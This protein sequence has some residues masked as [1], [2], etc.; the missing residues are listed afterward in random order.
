MRNFIAQWFRKPQSNPSPGTIVDSPT[1]RPQ[2]QPQTARQ[3]RMEASLASLRLLP[4]GV[5]R[6]LESSGHR[7]V[8]DLLRLNL[9]QW[10]TEQR[11]TASQQSQLRTVRRAIRMAFAL[12]AMHPREAYLL[13]AIHRRS[14]EDVASDSPRHLFRDLE[15]FALSSRGRALT[16]RI[17]IPSLERVSAWIAAAQDHQFSRLA[18]SHTSSASDTAGVSPAPSGH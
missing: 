3:R 15:R 8:Q 6:Q 10:A 1:G 14:P 11:L 18:T 16:R 17:E 5:L 9:S 13:I 7:R 4:T 2:A 12:R